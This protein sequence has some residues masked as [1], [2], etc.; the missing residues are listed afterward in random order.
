[1]DKPSGT[2]NSP[3]LS[4]GSDVNKFV[5]IIELLASCTR[6]HNHASEAV[7]TLPYNRTYLCKIFSSEFIIDRF[8]G[9]QKLHVIFFM[10]TSVAAGQISYRLLDQRIIVRKS[11]ISGFS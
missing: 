9:V 4:H 10:L 11:S 6:G 5:S 7:R 8:V 2:F 3:V 1:V